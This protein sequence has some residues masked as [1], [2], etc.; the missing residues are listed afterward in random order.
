VPLELYLT[1]P[2]GQQ[3]LGGLYRLLEGKVSKGLPI[4]KRVGDGQEAWIYSG[5]NGRWYISNN[6]AV[7]V[8]DFLCGR[9]LISSSEHRNLLPVMLEEDSWQYK[10]QYGWNKDLQICFSITPPAAPER[11]FISSPNAFQ[12]LSG[13]YRL[14]TSH[15]NGDPMWQRVGWG[16]EAYL[17]S[18][19]S[20]KWYVV[21]KHVV[22]ERHFDCNL[23][24]LVSSH[25][26]AGLPPDAFVG[27]HRGWGIRSQDGWEQ[28]EEIRIGTQPFE[29]PSASLWVTSPNSR[30][31]GRF[32]LLE[33]QFTNGFPLWRRA[34]M[35]AAMWLYSGNKGKWCVG[36]HTI[37]EHYKFRC[38]HGFLMSA[39][40][41][42]G[43]RPEEMENWSTEE[44]SSS[45]TV[46]T[47]KVPD[48][49]EVMYLIS[50]NGQQRKAGQ[51]LLVK[52]I[53]CNGYPVWKS[54]DGKRLLYTGNDGCWYFGGSQEVTGCDFNCAS[55][56]VA[57]RS[58]GG[59][60]PHEIGQ[61]WYLW[62]D[63]GWEW[64]TD[65]EIFVWLSPPAALKQLYLVCRNGSER[66]AGTY[67]LLEGQSANTMPLWK[68]EGSGEDLYIY[69]G[70]D[71]KWHVGDQQAARKGFQCDLGALCSCLHGAAMPNMLPSGAWE[72]CK[73]QR[74]EPDNSVACLARL[75]EYP[76]EISILSP[77]GQQKVAG[78]YLLQDL[79]ANGQRI[80]KR[81]GTG[82]GE[83]LW[84]YSGTSGYW[85]V[86][87]TKAAQ[88]AFSCT[89]GNLATAEQHGGVL[90][91]QNLRWQVR[92]ADGWRDD[93][94]VK[95]LRGPLSFPPVLYLVTETPVK[96][97]VY[98]LLKAEFLNG[99]PLWRCS[100]R[101]KDSWLYSTADGFWCLSKKEHPTLG[102]GC[103]LN[104]LASTQPHGGSMPHLLETWQVRTMKGWESS[105][106]LLQTNPP[107]SPSVLHV[108]VIGDCKGWEALVG[109]Y[110]RLEGELMYHRPVWRQ[111]T[112]KDGPILFSTPDGWML[113][114][115]STVTECDLPE[116]HVTALS[117]GAMLGKYHSMP[118]VPGECACW[119][120]SEEAL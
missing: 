7:E 76:G 94:E 32:D 55:G 51:Y 8:S 10:D 70:L 67:G 81:L 79:W 65:D 92:N 113:Q 97:A 99:Q 34:G 52:D 104:T 44:G 11:L 26:H 63:E 103:S 106:A 61:E 25:P 23:G 14:C 12:K 30:A 40:A 93:G 18:G 109:K 60:L 17:Y 98:E 53:M 16:E 29:S 49:P 13:E 91:F 75:P 9:G 46:V 110:W 48:V 4:W 100:E 35:G 69:S 1:S 62:N 58:H 33:G 74:G 107:E 27:S 96:D 78:R 111:A 42:V 57:S 115:A 50:P 114:M 38:N 117:K 68:R 24:G 54:C 37:V 72:R 19:R 3:K 41:H 101:G 21:C 116:L 36:D 66:L 102:S 31:T 39:M 84:L 88:K 56:V 112:S 80:W 22:V 43:Q 71:G 95:V 118:P 119:K 64:Q 90:P 59:V 15:A 86:A 89:L 120:L 83:Q 20:G 87:G 5:P 108:E 105:S 45:S 77:A 2:N 73:G 82:G 47:T 28:D 85:H 6:K